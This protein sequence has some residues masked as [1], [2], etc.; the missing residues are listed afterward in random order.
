MF[1]ESIFSKGA[2]Y[3]AGEEFTNIIARDEETKKKDFSSKGRNKM[4]KIGEERH[5]YIMIKKKLREMVVV[6]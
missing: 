4:I 5:I 3:T 2:L 1:I 6:G